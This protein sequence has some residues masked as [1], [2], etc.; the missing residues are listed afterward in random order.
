[1]WFECT[2]SFYVPEVP[3]RRKQVKT[4]QSKKEKKKKKKKKWCCLCA[5]PLHLSADGRGIRGEFKP[6][7]IYKGPHYWSPASS[8]S[9]SVT[10]ACS[11][12]ELL[13]PLV[14]VTVLKNGHKYILN[15]LLDSGNQ[16]SYLSNEV[17]NGL[18]IKIDSL[19]A[20]Q[21]NMKKFLGED[22]QCLKEVPINIA[23]GDNSLS[24]KA[25]VWP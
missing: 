25:F 20:L 24:I 5:S 17:A 4:G 18:N 16:R 23:V 19:P 11:N 22:M 14:K 2:R 3:N 8:P 7:K 1:M 12:K 6:C 9:L 10:S 15:C 13:L 21:F